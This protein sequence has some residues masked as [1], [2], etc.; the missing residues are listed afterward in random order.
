MVVCGVTVQ[1][2]SCCLRV[3]RREV[4]KAHNALGLCLALS[5]F[6]PVPPSSDLPAF[7][8]PSAA[9]QRLPDLAGM[10][11]LCYGRCK[12]LPCGR[13][14][15]GTAIAPSP[16]RP[17]AIAIALPS[18]RLLSLLL[19]S[20]PRSLSSSF[21]LFLSLLPSELSSFKVC[22]PSACQSFFCP[23]SFFLP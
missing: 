8:R 11:H 20:F 18:M 17:F 12:S 2:G 19:S 4:C 13:R 10:L 6:S 9:V 3:E 16:P 21:S 1:R 14:A 22:R 23:L 7:F 15:T 5:P